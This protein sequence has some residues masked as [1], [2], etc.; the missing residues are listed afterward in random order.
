M[1]KRTA[2]WGH[3][4]P[5][6]T[7]GAAADATLAINPECLMSVQ[8]V[9]N[10]GPTTIHDGPALLFGVYVNTVLSAHTVLLKDATDSKITLPA[11]LAAGSNLN[12]YGARFE[13]SL[14]IQPNA[15]STGVVVVFYRPI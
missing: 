12:F 3:Y 10:D 15:S 6:T 11:S 7:G 8:D 4:I 5:S 9:V 13:T 1:G 14:I 2:T